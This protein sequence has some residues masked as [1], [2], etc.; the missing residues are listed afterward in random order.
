MAYA[1]I[2]SVHARPEDLN[3]EFS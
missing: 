2:S 1:N 3:K